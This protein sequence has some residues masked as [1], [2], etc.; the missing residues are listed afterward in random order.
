MERSE[1]VVFVKVARQVVVEQI[2]HFV[3]SHIF[4]PPGLIR[5]VCP[6]VQGDTAHTHTAYTIIIPDF[7]ELVN[8]FS[9]ILQRNTAIFDENAFF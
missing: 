5:H 7:L 2:E 4:S 6:D 1:I 9:G 8:R 3:F